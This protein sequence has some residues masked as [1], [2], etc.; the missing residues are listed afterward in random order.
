MH[1]LA[2]APLCGAAA[3][4]APPRRR[5]APRRVAV[6]PAA[7]FGGLFGGGGKKESGDS[8]AFPPQAKSPLPPGASTILEGTIL[9]E[10]AMQLSYDA[11]RDGWT[12]SAFHKGCDNRVRACAGVPTHAVTPSRH[13]RVVDVLMGPVV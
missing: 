7:L 2:A 8:A 4:R 9:D 12:A 6:S 11:A 1:G 13:I 3:L 10:Q 5:C